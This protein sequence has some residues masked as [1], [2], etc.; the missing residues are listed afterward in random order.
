VSLMDRQWHYIRNTGTGKEELF[1]YRDD[2]AEV[3]DLLAAPESEPIL[4]QLRTQ[5]DSLV[6]SRG[7]TD[8]QAPSGR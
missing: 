6:R 7:K 4:R 2:P 1:R 8:P 5:T 3:S